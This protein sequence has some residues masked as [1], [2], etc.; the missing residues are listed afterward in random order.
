MGPAGVVVGVQASACCLQPEGWTPT[1]RQLLGKQ[2]RQS[3][4]NFCVYP[5]GHRITINEGTITG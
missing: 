5:Q 2:G 1:K 3:A 4:V